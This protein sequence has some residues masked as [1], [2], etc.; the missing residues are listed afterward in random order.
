M[1]P[2]HFRV[3]T[4][5]P[6]RCDERSKQISFGD[7]VTTMSLLHNL[8]Q[9]ATGQTL[10]PDFQ[11]SQGNKRRVEVY[12][13]LIYKAQLRA[14]AA[15]TVEVRRAHLQLIIRLDARCKRE[16]RRREDQTRP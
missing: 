6:A 15:D 2:F 4:A 3:V 9:A 13:A 7:S 16:V 5:A 14:D 1:G 11:P 12:D 8:W 10:P